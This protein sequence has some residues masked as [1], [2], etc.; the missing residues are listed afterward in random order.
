[1][2][3]AAATV[4]LKPGRDKSVRNRHP[5]LFSG[6]LK[7]MRGDAQS[8]EVVD[9][10][11][12][13][14]EWLARGIVHR[15]AQIAVRLLTWNPDEVID[16]AFWWRRVQ[17]AVYRRHLDPLLTTT[18]AHRLIFGESDGVPGVIVDEYAG[19]LVLQVSALAGVNAL[20]TLR[21]ALIEM[22]QPQTIVVRADEERLKQEYG[23]KLDTQTYGLGQQPDPVTILEDQ[24]RFLVQLHRGQ[25]TGF[26]LDQRQNRRRLRAYCQNA[27]VLNLFSYTG[28]FGV[29]AA[30]AGANRVVNV[31]SSAEALKLAAQMVELN[32][33]ACAQT[34]MDYVCADAFAEVR[35]R[36]A[37]GE[38]FD[39]VILDPPKLAQTPGQV[40]RAARAYKDLNRVGLS[41]VKPGGLLVTFSCSGVVDAALFQKI[42]FSAAIEA[43]R[44]TQIV[45]RLTQASD[46]PVA[47]TFPE[48]DYLKGLILRV[49]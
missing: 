8:G 11:S 24:L 46:H 36:R 33:S 30:A 5:R 7:E 38:Q 4:I 3:L 47:L 27:A 6:A 45:E 12:H 49:E 15:Q 29:V 2:S 25:K 26:Y 9:V 42:L 13:A 41:L 28:A 23:S 1:M 17:A 39:L 44:E 35:S 16:S 19:H 37:A 21:D 10:C 31:D 40:N 32:Q 34:Q 14:G 20:P 22:V 43:G 48:A 18:N